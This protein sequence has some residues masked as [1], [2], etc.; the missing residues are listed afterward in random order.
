MKSR[1]SVIVLWLLLACCMS[2][3]TDPGPFSV[4]PAWAVTGDGT[5]LAE[6]ED[7][8]PDEDAA[9]PAAQENQPA[10]TLVDDPSEG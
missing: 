10:E 5:A 4:N 9:E 6:I 1:L 2:F 3:A 7:I 8:R